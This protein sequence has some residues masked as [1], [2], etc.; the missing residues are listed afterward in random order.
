MEKTQVMRPG[1][2]VALKTSMNGGVQY[3]RRDLEEAK[4]GTLARWET[5][6]LMDDPAEHKLAQVTMSAASNAISRLCVR[7]GFGLLCPTDRED[8][9]DKAIAAAR[10]TV[11]EWNL[12][13]S[14]TWISVNAVKGR[15]ADNDEEA[16]R[17]LLA[18]ATELVRR[19]DDGLGR[20]DVRMIREAANKARALVDIMGDDA[21]D[22]VTEAVKAARKA[23]REIVRRVGVEGETAQQV[24]TKVNRDAFDKARFTFL[25]TAES[26][27]EALPAIDGQRMAE[28]EA[29]REESKSRR[30]NS[31]SDSE[32]GGD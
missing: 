17:A 1:I 15:I 4:D 14:H 3:T 7:T 27:L 12:T 11:D 30:R 8:E 32:E 10:L 19:M 21:G 18:E 5:E 22:K 24:V 23:A 20:A 25:D 26:E 13:A 9:L 2:L 6:R 16:V 31:K 28:I 29:Y